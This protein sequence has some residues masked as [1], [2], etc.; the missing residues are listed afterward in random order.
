MENKR[1]KNTCCFFG[2]RTIDETD[3]LQKNVATVVERL[4]AQEG[5][6]TFL[7]GSKSR[8]DELCLAIVTKLK[9]KY[10]HIKRVYVRAEFPVIDEAYFIYLQNFYEETYYPAQLVG[11]GRA[12]Y[13]KRNREM[14]DQSAF[15]VVYHDAHHAPTGRKSGTAVALE[16]AVKRGK[17]VFHVL[18]R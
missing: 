1:M 13:V 9:E 18:P 6:D 17:C 2:H 10:P 11:A 16:Y 14:I 15:C 7:F 3:A 5:V 12:V 8:F 4:I